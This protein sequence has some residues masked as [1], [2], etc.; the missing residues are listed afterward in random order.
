MPHIRLVTTPAP[1][2]VLAIAAGTDA[3][4][5]WSEHRTLEAAIKEAW[6]WQRAGL[7]DLDVMKRL[8]DGTLTTEF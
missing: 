1:R 2:W 5:V 4:A 8:P 3:Q 7:S 6:R